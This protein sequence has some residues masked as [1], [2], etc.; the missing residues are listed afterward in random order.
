MQSSGTHQNNRRE[1][2]SPV[3]AP[4]MTSVHEI[5]KRVTEVGSSR[6]LLCLLAAA[7]SVLGSPRHHCNMPLALT[8]GTEARRVASIVP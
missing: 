4:G 5:D 7:G 1:I 6:G 2:S 3:A 8:D